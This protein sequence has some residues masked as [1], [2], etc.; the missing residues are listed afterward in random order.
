M[1]EIIKNSLTFPTR[2]SYIKVWGNHTETYLFIDKFSLRYKSVTKKVYLTKMLLEKNNLCLR[3]NFVF[4]RK[5]FIVCNKLEFLHKIA[6]K[7]IDLGSIFM[8]KS[9]YK[10]YMKVKWRKF[11]SFAVGPL[12][13]SAD[14]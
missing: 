6:Y 11:F 9:S 4:V 10:F 7:L 3:Y 1:L 12:N 8:S 5:N 2:F 14:F 13:K